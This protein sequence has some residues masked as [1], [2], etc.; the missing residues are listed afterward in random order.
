MCATYFDWLSFLISLFG[1][2]WRL[3]VII[4][5]VGLVVL[6]SVTGFV[7]DFGL[8]G[9]RLVH[10]RDVKSFPLLVAL[11]PVPFINL[12]FGDVEASG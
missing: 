7:D 2:L 4:S 5:V 11:V 8:I 12:G 1:V 6:I 10:G 9:G 3:V